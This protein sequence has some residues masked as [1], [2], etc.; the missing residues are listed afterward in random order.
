[1]DTIGFKYQTV[2]DMNFDRNFVWVAHAFINHDNYISK[3]KPTEVI[4][5]TIMSS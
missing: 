2:N 4:S 3:L 5:S 1:M